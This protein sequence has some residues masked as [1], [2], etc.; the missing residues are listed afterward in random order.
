MSKKVTILAPCSTSW[1]ETG[2]LTDSLETWDQIY[3]S[4]SDLPQVQQQLLESNML[5]GKIK[6]KYINK[7][8]V[9]LYKIKWQHSFQ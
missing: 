9:F 3:L 7:K 5:M 4:A 8:G 6:K 2:I 1:L